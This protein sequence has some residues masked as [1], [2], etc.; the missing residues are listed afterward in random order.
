MNGIFAVEKPSGLSS[1]KVVLQIQNIFD[2]SDVF[3]RDLAEAKHK[4]HEQLTAGTKWLESKIAKR[5]KNTKIK[6]GHG[7]TLDPLASG[8][9][10]IGVG[11]GTKK[12]S[13]YLGECTKTYETRAILGQSTTTGDSE[14]EVLTQTEVEH[15]NL[16]D[17]RKAANKFVGKIKQTP[18]IFSALKV[19]GKPLYEYAREGIPLPVAIKVREVD[20]NLL[21]VHD[22]GQNEAFSPLKCE[23]DE[24]GNSVQSML[25][26]NPSLNDSELFYSEEFMNDS[27]ISADEKITTIKPKLVQLT[28]ATLPVFHATASVGSGTYIRSLISDLGKAV[29]SSAHMVELI[30]TKQSDWE[31]GKNVFTL[32]DFERDSKVWGPVLKKTF[33]TGAEINLAEEFAKAT[34]QLSE[35]EGKGDEE[36]KEPTEEIKESLEEAKDAAGEAGDEPDA[37]KRKMD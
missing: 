25:A 34:E 9:L 3:S 16:E 27:T 10:I 32:A 2:N 6:V 17:L 13:Y 5:V 8:V 14:G 21:E 36:A 20:V 12:L 19:S 26:S 28:P 33:D 7:G 4:V 37:K 22:F 24:S 35:L 1:S 30:R 29:G 18:P 31:L 11:T 23:T 15:V